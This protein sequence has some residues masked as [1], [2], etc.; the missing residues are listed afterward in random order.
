MMMSMS[1]MDMIDLPFHQLAGTLRPQ[2]FEGRCGQPPLLHIEFIT[3]APGGAHRKRLLARL[4]GVLEAAP[5]R[6]ALIR[7]NKTAKVDHAMD[8]V[9]SSRKPPPFE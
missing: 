2:V 3:E 8:L 4:I 1:P 6:I 9:K 5:D 7:L